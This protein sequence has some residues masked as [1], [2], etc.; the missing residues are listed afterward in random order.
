MSAESVITFY[1]KHYERDAN[2]KMR[3]APVQALETWQD[4]ANPAPEIA[5]LRYVLNAMTAAKVPVSKQ[6]QNVMKR[7]LVQLPELPVKQQN[8]VTILLPAERT[9][10]K[11]KNT[12][13]PELY[14]VFPFRIYGAN[15][16]HLE[17]GR[18]TFEAR[19]NKT[20]GGWAQ[21]SIQAAYLG[22]SKTARQLVTESFT[23]PAA[24]RFPAF[25]GPTND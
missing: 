8:G 1:D 24:G 9:S 14:A 10:G 4:A 16:P 22:F 13:N 17:V 12:E 19:R 5:G 18:A 3:I 25:W 15:K 6:L 21:D 7:M 11:S 23:T 2:G 20:N